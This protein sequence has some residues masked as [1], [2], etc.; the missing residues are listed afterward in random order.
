[1]LFLRQFLIVT[2]HFPPQDVQVGRRGQVPKVWQDSVH[3][4]GGAGRGAKVAQ[5]V[6]QVLRVWQDA[7]QVGRRVCT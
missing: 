3:G 6:L 1:M 7:G 5:T 2:V 4:R